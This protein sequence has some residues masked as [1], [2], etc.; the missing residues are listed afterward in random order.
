MP[1]VCRSIRRTTDL[2]PFRGHL[3]PTHRR[4]ER[5]EHLPRPPVDCPPW[6]DRLYFNGYVPNLQVG[7][8]VVTFLTHHLGYPIPSPAV[9]NRI[10][11]RFRG[12]SAD[13]A[14]RERIPVVRFAKD[15]R[16][17]DVMGPYLAPGG[18]DRP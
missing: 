14:D 11:E 4:C 7:G 17:A 6:T 3:V 13:F 5:G 8:Q 16:K 2:F 10:G 18:R 12:R 15:D 1:L 9:F